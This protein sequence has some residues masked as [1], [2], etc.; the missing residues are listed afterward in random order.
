MNVWQPRHAVPR[1]SVPEKLRRK[2]PP[3]LA[4]DIEP[5]IWRRIQVPSPITLAELHLVILAAMGCENYHLYSLGSG[6]TEYGEPDP[7]LQLRNTRSGRL[8]VVV[9]GPRAKPR[10]TCDFG[11]SWE[12]EILVQKAVPPEAGVRNPLCMDEARARPPEDYG[13][14]WGYAERL[15]S[16]SEIPSATST[17]SDWRGLAARSI[18]RRSTSMRSTPRCAACGS[19]SGPVYRCAG[20]LASAARYGLVRRVCS[21]HPYLAASCFAALTSSAGGF[22][23]K[24]CGWCASSVSSILPRR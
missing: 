9:P 11:D 12:H 23:R 1:E 15:E 16:L 6:G 13:G 5:P 10:Y 7:E 24:W 20:G 4:Q 17:R 18:R 22:P 21:V 3:H 8:D 19:H 2:E 14:V